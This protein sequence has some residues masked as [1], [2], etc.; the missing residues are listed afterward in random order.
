ML[1]TRSVEIPVNNKCIVFKQ[2]RSIEW[3]LLF[4]KKRDKLDKGPEKK[5]RVRK[6]KVKSIE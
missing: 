6:N 1:L 4:R 3:R 5:D 2:E